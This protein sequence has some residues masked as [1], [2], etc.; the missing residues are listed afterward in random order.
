MNRSNVLSFLFLSFACLAFFGCGKPIAVVDAGT[1]EGTI[2]KVVPD[3]VEIY[4][5]LENGEQL[6]LYFTEETELVQDGE[7]VDFSAIS[8]GDSVE[9]T[10]EREGNRNIPVR[11][12]LL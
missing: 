2:D 3:E 9:L 6:E 10:V 11:V 4:V 12:E 7:S 1:Y 5:S 8:A